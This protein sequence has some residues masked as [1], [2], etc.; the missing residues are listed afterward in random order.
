MTT[1]TSL[2]GKTGG[3]WSIRTSN[4]GTGDPTRLFTYHTSQPSTV[5]GGQASTNEEQRDTGDF[6][7]CMGVTDAPVREHNWE[8]A[9][10]EVGSVDD[11]SRASP[12]SAPSLSLWN[13]QGSLSDISPTHRSMSPDTDS[14][15]GAMS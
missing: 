1:H 8:A 7:H 9:C 5:F 10:S 3:E 6:A 2:S 12:P 14:T 4:R 11:H 13:T 15:D